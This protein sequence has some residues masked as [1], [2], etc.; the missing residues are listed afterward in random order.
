MHYM[1]LEQ[2]TSQLHSDIS[3][4]A[5]PFFTCCLGSV[6]TL[7]HLSELQVNPLH[8]LC[9]LCAWMTAIELGHRFQ[10]SLVSPL[11]VLQKV[12]FNF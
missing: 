5:V 4:K 7:V 9:S 1:K 6:S 3:L 2:C 10:V 12:E 11:K 8:M